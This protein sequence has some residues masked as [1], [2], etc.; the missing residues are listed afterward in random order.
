MNRQ[1]VA[2]LQAPADQAM[3]VV[4][5]AAGVPLGQVDSA[6]VQG[7]LVDAA[8]LGVSVPGWKKTNR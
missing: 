6:L 2:T 5:P 1:H 7:V 3:S 8:F 4:K